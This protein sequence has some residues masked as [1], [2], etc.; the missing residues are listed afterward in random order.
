[1]LS[2]SNFEV[3]LDTG[4]RVVHFCDACPEYCGDDR[5]DTPMNLIQARWTPCPECSRL[6]HSGKGNARIYCHLGSFTRP[7]RW[8][9]EEAWLWC[10][11]V[12]GYRF[13]GWRKHT[14]T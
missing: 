12:N 2:D 4:T 14:H 6:F 10:Y 1:M 3:S 8:Y 7:L 11:E 9:K 13:G 5:C